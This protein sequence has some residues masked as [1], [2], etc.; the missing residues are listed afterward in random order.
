MIKSA[1]YISNQ[2]ET[3]DHT[4]ILRRLSKAATHELWHQRLCH[5][6]E[7]VTNN[8]SR[9]TEGVPNL[10]QGRND[11]YKCETCMRA[12]MKRMKKFKLAP[13]VKDNMV[14]GAGQMFHMDFGFVRGSDFKIKEDDGRIITSR[15][16]YNSYLIIVDKFSSYTWIMLSRSKDPPLEFVR[17]FLDTHRDKRGPSTRI[18]TD[19]GGELWASSEFQEAIRDSKCLL[20]PTGAGD[21]AQNGK[22][23]SPNKTFGNMMRG[24]LYNAGLG[25]EFWL[26]ALVHA[27]YVKN[28]LPHSSHHMSKTPYEAYTGIKPNLSMLRVCGCRVV[29]KKPQTRN[30][31]LDD[32]TTQGIFLRYTATDKNIVYLDTITNQEKI[33]SHIIFDEANF[34]IGSSAPGAKALRYAGSDKESKLNCDTATKSISKNVSIKVKKL[35]DEARLPKRA[36]PHA[37]GM[38]IYSPEPFTINANSTTKMIPTGI[39]V[40]IPRGMYGRFAPR[41]GL[42]V[43]KQIDVKA[44]VV[45]NDFRG[46][47]TV[48]LRN[49]GDVPQTFNVGDKI[50]QLILEKYDEMEPV[51]WS[52]QLDETNRGDKGFGSS[53][54][55]IY[56]INSPQFDDTNSFI[57]S[58]NP[59]GPSLTVT[60]RIRGNHET[61][62]FELDD[63]TMSN[64]LILLNCKK[65]TPAAR[66]PKWRSQLRGAML[67]AVNQKKVQTMEEVV[68]TLDELRV[69]VASQKASQQVV[70]LTFVTLEK[71]SIHPQ[72]GVPQLYF[73]Q[74]NIIARHNLELKESATIMLDDNDSNDKDDWKAK[75]YKL[76]DESTAPA[77]H[78]KDA[79]IVEKLT[80]RILMKRDDWHEWKKSEA[81]QLDQYE[82]QGM[83]SEPVPRPIKA[84]ILNLLWTYLIKADGTKKARCCCNGNPGHKGSITLAHTY[85]ACVEQP[86]QR[87]YWGL[88]AVKNFIA[89]GADASNA[90][91]E[92]PPPKAPL[93]VVIDKQYREWYKDK[94]NI[95]VPKGYTLRVQ[96]AIQGHPEAPRLWSEFIDTIIREKLTLVPTTHEK[97]LYKGIFEGQEILFL[98]QVDDFSIASADEATCN[99]VITEISKYLKAPLKNLGRVTRFNGVEVQQT[100]K[101]VKLHNSQYIEK[102]LTR[103]GWMHDKYNPVKKL[104]PMRSDSKYLFTLENSKGP[105]NDKDRAMLE[106]KMKFNYRQ[107]LG[108]ILYAMVT[109][110]P[111][112]SISITKLSQYSQNPSEEHYIALKNVFR[113]LRFTKNDGLIF[114]RNEKATFKNLENGNLPLLYSD[115]AI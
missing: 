9:T 11:F 30:T 40:S 112:I 53:D 37:A 25:S 63:Q 108:E 80:R 19:Q 42:T 49:M 83:F 15:D 67:V 38:D 52:M 97:C 32:N 35:H 65:G 73:D 8:I 56:K 45:D 93:Y 78:Q 92:A 18:R 91:A 17:S 79:R 24:M 26:Y 61:L 22:A 94:Y 51:E 23:E 110:R 68:R 34:S 4:P 14:H 85:A 66:V 41:S 50:A 99:K 88:V 106:Q 55:K 87:V 111:D 75:I 33:A 10:S 74:L 28:H 60:T 104:V 36:T 86:A 115:D 100:A 76:G 98:R 101:Y 57:L 48:V 12:K 62:G 70:D 39:A 71:V 90:F 21:P 13:S 95:N 1:T 31:K 44:G 105:E 46:E 69:K 72:K 64:R 77:A 27:A 47:L 84:N 89:I 54:A 6:G 103:H 3:I 5:P 107:A 102:I 114:W 81:K 96:H 82:Q 113:Y 2:L 109:C 20:E 16:G 59:Y 29:V 43:K 58:N 7:S